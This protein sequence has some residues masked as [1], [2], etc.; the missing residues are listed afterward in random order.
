MV[1]QF[2]QWNLNVIKELMDKLSATGLASVTIK[3]GDFAVVI[4]AKKTPDVILPPQGAAVQAA[5]PMAQS[6]GA[7]V[8]VNVQPAPSAAPEGNV[9]KSPIVGT[10]YASAA[11]DKPPFVQIGSKV[12]KGDTL[13]VIESMKLM[14]EIQSDFT[15][16]VTEILVDNAQGVEY[17]QPVMVIK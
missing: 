15:G 13:F 5:A 8:E 7:S 10:F 2:G 6:V 17:N 11:P 12:K 4:E 3:D 14:N 9:V 16:E 1:E